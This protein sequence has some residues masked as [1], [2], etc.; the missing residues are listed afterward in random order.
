MKFLQVGLVSCGFLAATAGAFVPISPTKSSG[1]SFPARKST[2][3]FHAKA[4]E[5]DC[6]CASP[7][8]DTSVP[9]MVATKGSGNAFRSAILTDADGNMVRLGDKMGPN[10]SVVIFLRHLG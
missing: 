2:G 7:E 10:K 4:L 5:N 1:V 9:S 3:S 6:E 8:E